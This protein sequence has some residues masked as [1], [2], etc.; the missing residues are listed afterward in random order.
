MRDRA[1]GGS[2]GRCDASLRRKA[3]LQ[4]E[5]TVKLVADRLREREA[6]S[7]VEREEEHSAWMIGYQDPTQRHP[8]D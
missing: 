1:R 5:Q 3:D 6:G 8:H 7:R 4:N 2:A